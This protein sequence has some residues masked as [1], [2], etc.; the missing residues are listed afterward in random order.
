MLKREYHGND[1]SVQIEPV[2][3]EVVSV[4][5]VRGGQRVKLDGEL[6]GTKWEGIDVE[7]P[8]N[9]DEAQVTRIVRELEEAFAALGVGYVITRRVGHRIETLAKSKEF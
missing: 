9:V 3:R 5:H 6:I 2:F 4:T 8:P 1:F 7:L